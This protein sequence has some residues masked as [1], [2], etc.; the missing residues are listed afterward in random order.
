MK[1]QESA[2]RSSIDQRIAEGVPL[3]DII[4]ALKAVFELASHE[5]ASVFDHLDPS[6][7][8]YEQ[9][10]RV[11]LAQLTWMAYISAEWHRLY[12]I[13]EERNR[14]ARVFEQQGN[15]V[16]AIELYEANVRDGF[17]GPHPYERLRI[18]YTSHGQYTDAIRVCQA[19]LKLPDRPSGSVSYFKYHLRRLLFHE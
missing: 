18:L 12:R 7:P 8:D 6:L 17:D 19:Y 5:A 10:R 4:A 3:A 16:G 14:Q 1:E 15:V 2:L 9:K 11:H 13:M